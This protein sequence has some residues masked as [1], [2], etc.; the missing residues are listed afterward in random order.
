MIREGRTH[1]IVSVLNANTK[2]TELVFGGVTMKDTISSITDFIFV[3]DKPVIVDALL[4][5]GSS[6]P[7]IP[8]C[9]AEL[10]QSGFAPLVIPSGGASIK[11]GKFAGVK[12][13]NKK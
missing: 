6:D 4:L 9:A 3:E 1:V 12:R 2:D 7:A 8:E 10:F 5:P 13:K 11:T